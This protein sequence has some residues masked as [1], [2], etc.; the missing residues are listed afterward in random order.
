MRSKIRIEDKE[1]D[2][3]GLVKEIDEGLE[4]K[5]YVGKGDYG[6]VLKVTDHDNVYKLKINWANEVD[7]RT[8]TLEREYK[9][10][11]DLANKTGIVPKPIRLYD[12][13]KCVWY[14][15]KGKHAYLAEFIEGKSLS[16]SEKQSEISLTMELN[17]L[18]DKVHKAGYRFNNEAD[19]NPD[20][21]IL[22]RDGKLY[23]IDTMFLEPLKERMPIRYMTDRE[24]YMRNSIIRRC[25]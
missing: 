20:N 8:D 4:F 6:I 5:E 10:L 11:E 24:R 18:I 16:K 17:D 7:G 22:G 23:L 12:D 14:N 9:T 1:I 2:L 25:T 13:A 3:A 21:I 19:L 15:I